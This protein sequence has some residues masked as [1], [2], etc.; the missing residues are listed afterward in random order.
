VR[1]WS[2]W[3]GRALGGLRRS[4]APRGARDGDQGDYPEWL[5]RH[6]AE[7]RDRTPAGADPGLLSLITCLY[8]GSPAELFAE[9][10][11]CVLGQHDGNFEWIILA[12]GAL[13]ATLGG[14]V[15]RAADDERVHLLSS[16]ENLGIMRGLRVCLEAAVG[17]Y[18]LPLDG[19]DLLTS[20]AVGVLRHALAVSGSPA[21]LYGDEDAWVDGEPRHPYLRPDWDPVLNLTSSYIW[22]PSVFRRDSA[23][24]LGVFTDV[25]SEYCQDWDT[26]FRFARAGCEPVH[27]SEIL[28]HWRAHEGSSTHRADRVRGS[29]E[30]QRH[31]LEEE[32]RAR[33]ESR[34]FEIVESP[35]DRGLPE[36]WVRRRRDQ[37]PRMSTILVDYADAAE[38][39]DDAWQLPRGLDAAPIGRY[40]STLYLKDLSA[41]LGASDAD[42]VL[43][44]DA[45]LT[46]LGGEW[47]RE[48]F[49]LLD[50]FPR[51]VAVGGRVIDVS[52]SVRTGE[53]LVAPG[54]RLLCPDEGRER[55][56]PGYYA[57]ALKPHLTDAVTG[58]LV[59]VRRAWLAECLTR[60]PG[61]A[62]LSFL[63]GWL[64]ALAAEGVGQIAYSPIIAATC[65]AGHA[66]DETCTDDERA[67]FAAAWGSEGSL[68]RWETRLRAAELGERRPLLGQ[69]SA[70]SAGGF[71]ISYRP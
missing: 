25:E 63:G 33:P 23:L 38:G 53:L 61:L 4:A 58:R 24:D 19:D 30:S 56:D 2:T 18:V 41:L 1:R 31:V 12:N 46:P 54:A 26:V 69:H 32:L 5:R 65:R 55:E 14:V 22:H 11:D 16:P 42:V 10:R 50:L 48:A 13:P 34:M 3:L 71:P 60:L 9:T 28:Y 67:A 62:T 49:G 37:V 44:M 20:D 64:G 57:F 59:F 21:F 35:L 43:F 27:I 8:D 17:A 51:L 45:S 36:W 7:R 40:P 15:A 52:G 47:L 6:V 68:S 39:R 70:Y 66:C 29:L